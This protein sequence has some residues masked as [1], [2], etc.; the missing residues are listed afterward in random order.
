MKLR[1]Y[2]KSFAR[3]L[4]SSK[5]LKIEPSLHIIHS[6]YLPLIFYVWI[7]RWREPAIDMKIRFIDFDKARFETIDIRMRY[8]TTVVLQWQFPLKCNLQTAKNKSPYIF[9]E[10]DIL[11]AFI[12]CCLIVEGKPCWRLDLKFCVFYSCDQVC[13]LLPSG[14]WQ[15]KRNRYK[16]ASQDLINAVQFFF[17]RKELTWFFPPDRRMTFNERE[18]TCKRKNNNRCDLST[19]CSSLR[20]HQIFHTFCG[21]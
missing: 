2:W 10:F 6:S 9:Y 18:L 7:F 14:L 1:Q 15:I 13:L 12:K 16:F 8:S 3:K 20:A 21:S 19:N 4:T 17:S 11:R 5:A